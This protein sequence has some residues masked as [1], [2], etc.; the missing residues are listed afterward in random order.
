MNLTTRIIQLIAGALGG[1]TAG[2]FP[3]DTNLGPLGNTIAGV[4]S[5][6][7]GGQ[8]LNAVLTLDVL[9]NATV[10]VLVGHPVSILLASNLGYLLAIILGLAAFI[11]LRKDRPN[12]PRPIRRSN[13]WIPVVAVLVVFNVFITVIGVLN[14]GLL[15]YGGA[16]ES[17]LAVGIL[18]FSVVLYVYR[19]VVQDKLPLVWRLPAPAMPEGADALA[20]ELE[21]RVTR[22][23]G[24]VHEEV[25]N[26]AGLSTIR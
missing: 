12:W 11:L 15:G 21:M 10:M 8:N 4:A 13:A 3:K 22:G 17:L 26:N 7:I 5:G 1:H 24:T 23:A 25:A 18:L 14:P 16:R 9:L 6:A 19:R 2:N 20:L